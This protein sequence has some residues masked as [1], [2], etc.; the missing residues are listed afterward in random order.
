MGRWRGYGAYER[1]G[2]D[3]V[4]WTQVMTLAVGLA[5]TAFGIWSRREW[6]AAEADHD[7][8]LQRQRDDGPDRDPAPGSP[9]VGSPPPPR[10]EL[11][12]EV[13]MISARALGYAAPFAIAVGSISIFVG[14]GTI[15]G[16]LVG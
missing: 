4:R 2:S 3:A 6:R 10:G 8:R 14:V 16:D 13:T 5:L 9:R 15:I 1:R 11:H 7:R 12:P